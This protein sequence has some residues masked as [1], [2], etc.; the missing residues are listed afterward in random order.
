MK[1]KCVYVDKKK[2]CFFTLGKVYECSRGK[3]K[4]KIH[5]Y[6]DVGSY[7]RNK[8]LDGLVYKFEIEEEE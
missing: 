7:W 8:L 2:G 1:V 3:N 6:D 5:I 4:K